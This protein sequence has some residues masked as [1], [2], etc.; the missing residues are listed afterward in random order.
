MWWHLE[1]GET[2]RLKWGMRNVLVVGTQFFEK[3][4]V[5]Y[6]YEDGFIYVISSDQLKSDGPGGAEGDGDGCGSNIWCWIIYLVQMVI[7]FFS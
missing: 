6:D 7:D 4:I 1:D 5:V 2:C 3:Y